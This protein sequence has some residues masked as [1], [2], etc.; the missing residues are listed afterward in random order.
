MKILLDNHASVNE[1]DKMK[2]CTHCL[3]LTEYAPFINQGFY[4]LPS[5]ETLPHSTFPSYSP[6]S[7]P[8]NFRFTPPPFPSFLSYPLLYHLALHFRRIPFL[9]IS[10]PCNFAFSALTL[11]VGWQEGI[12]PVKNLE[13]WVAGVVICLKQGADLHMSQLMPLPLTDSCFSK[14]Q[15]GCTFLVPAHPGSPGK[16]AIKRVCV[17]VCHFLVIPFIFPFSSHF[18]L[19]NAC[20]ITRAPLA[21][22][23]RARQVQ[24]GM[25][26]SPV[27]LYLADDWRLVSDSTR[28]SLRSADVSTCVLLPTL[29]SYG[30]RSFA[31][32]GPRLWNSPTDCSDDS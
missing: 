25:P 8:L 19:W 21:S 9:P 17:C 6:L 4:E 11:L 7:P 29:S 13:W 32:A 12:R 26:G 22:H 18:L 23:P 2:V 16:R 5:L 10:L 3:S 14:I 31:A 28:R 20:G 15:I 1:V 27:A 24:T 30:D